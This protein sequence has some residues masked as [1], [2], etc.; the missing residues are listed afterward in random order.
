MQNHK[1][2]TSL[3]KWLALLADWMTN[4][5][6]LVGATLVI[7]ILFG[8][9]LFPLLGELFVL[10]LET[11]ERVSDV[12]LETAFA[13]TPQSAQMV[14][15]WTGLG[16]LIYGIVWFIRKI[17]HFIQHE[18]KDQYHHI[19]DEIQASPNLAWLLHPWAIPMVLVFVVGCSV[20][21]F[22]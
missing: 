18:L 6:V 10:L 5:R 20:L 22:V 21:L 14:V 13:L 1:E 17:Q 19:H 8:D 7:F 9:A 11:L 16:L 12:L 15:A 2:T 3:P 4:K